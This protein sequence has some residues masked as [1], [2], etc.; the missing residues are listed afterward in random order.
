[1]R[2]RRDVP[3]NVRYWH[4]PEYWRWLWRERIPTEAR[5]VLGL[6]L[7]FALGVTGFVSAGVVTASQQAPPP[8]TQ[9]V[10]TVVRKAHPGAAPQTVTEREI[11]SK[12][13]TTRVVTV[14]RDGHTTVVRSPGRTIRV[15]GVRR[16]VVTAPGRTVTTPGQPTTVTTRGATVTTR[17]ATVTTPGATVTAPGET[18]LATVTSASPPSTVTLT[19]TMPPAHGDPDDPN[20]VTETTTVTV[21]VGKKGPG[22]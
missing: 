17:G 7:A 14:R 12:S 18:V 5:L 20:T 6:A 11:R 1:V 13:G 3:S 21:T 10:V 15:Q 19:V 2:E 16:Q 9:R 22:G 4:R 8:L